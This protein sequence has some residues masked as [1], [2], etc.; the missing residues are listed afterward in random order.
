[1]AKNKDSAY[2][3]EYWI[4]PTGNFGTCMWEIDDG[5][6]TI[7]RFDG[8]HGN[9]S[10]FIGE[11]QAVDGPSTGGSYTWIKT[12]CWPKWEHKLVYGPYIHHVSGVYGKYAD[13]FVEACKYLNNITADVAEP[14]SEELDNRWMF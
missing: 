2:A 9:Y 12:N 3:G 11:A 1:M 5:D 7:V 8:D 13:I 4:A 6:L 10:M 14:S